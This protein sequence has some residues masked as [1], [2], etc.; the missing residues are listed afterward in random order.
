ML[1]PRSARP[2][3]PAEDCLFAACISVSSINAPCA[4]ANAAA[5]HLATTA[6][7]SPSSTT[8]PS[9]SVVPSAAII[10]R[11]PSVATSP[12]VNSF[13]RRAS[14]YDKVTA[15]SLHSSG[16]S[17]IT[18]T[19][20][21]CTTPAAKISPAVALSVDQRIETSGSSIRR[22]SERRA[23]HIAEVGDYHHTLPPLRLSVLPLLRK[24]PWQACARSQ[25]PHQQQHR[26][27]PDVRRPY[28]PPVP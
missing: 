25:W 7:I 10:S 19:P 24:Q 11:C 13:G 4:V 26:L 15:I 16:A 22:D 12:S 14:H 28:L 3:A 1:G 8:V 9:L 27:W 20:I 2:L 23:D 17:W 5:I 18:A 6:L 21:V